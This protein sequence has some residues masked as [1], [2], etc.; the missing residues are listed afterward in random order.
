MQK[1]IV[2]EKMNVSVRRLML[3]KII[4][5]AINLKIPKHASNLLQYGYETIWFQTVEI[6]KHSHRFWETI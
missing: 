6:L 3:K 5:S 2:N 1:M 4:A